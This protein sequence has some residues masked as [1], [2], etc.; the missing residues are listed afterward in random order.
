VPLPSHL[1]FCTPTKSN[2]YLDNSLKIV[3]WE[4]TLYILHTFHVPR[5]F[6][7]FHNM[8]IFY[9]DWLLAPFLT[10][11]LEDPPCHL[12]AAAHSVYMQLPSIARG[13]PSIHNPRMHHAVVTRG[14]T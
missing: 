14:P 1:T 5:L 2:L 7:N 12:S 4:P 13:C 11:K 9:S 10:S 8:L 6:Q 3:I